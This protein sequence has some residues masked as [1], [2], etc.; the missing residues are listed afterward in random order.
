M[1]LQSMTGFGRGEASDAN[2]TVAIEIKSVNHR[3]KDLRFKMSSV[4]NSIEMDLRKMLSDHFK[5]GSFDIYI[6]FKRS[7]TNARFEDIDDEKVSAFLK[8]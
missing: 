6:N 2:Y 1:S 4:Y 3:F 8:K 5:R 7:E